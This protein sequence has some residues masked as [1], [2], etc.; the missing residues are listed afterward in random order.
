MKHL[1]H[2]GVLAL[3]LAACQGEPAD[4]AGDSSPADS[5]NKPAAAAD[6]DVTSSRFRLGRDI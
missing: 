1:I 6:A 5:S 3:F 2:V 4:G